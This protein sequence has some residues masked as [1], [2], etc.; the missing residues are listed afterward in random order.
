MPNPW[1]KTGADLPP[2]LTRGEWDPGWLDL[3][4]LYEHALRRIALETDEHGEPSAAARMA[5]ETL[6]GIRY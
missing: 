3:A 1:P 6:L 5:Y 4:S 2:H